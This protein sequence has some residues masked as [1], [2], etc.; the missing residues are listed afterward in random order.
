[1]FILRVTYGFGMASRIR[2]F[3]DVVVII[4]VYDYDIRFSYGLVY[5]LF[6]DSCTQLPLRNERNGNTGCVTV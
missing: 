4:E 6:M 2:E 5:D 3:Y 1:M